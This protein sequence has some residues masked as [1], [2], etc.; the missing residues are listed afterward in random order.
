[1]WIEQNS[2]QFYQAILKKKIFPE[3]PNIIASYLKFCVD[4]EFKDCKTLSQT[5][6]KL[7]I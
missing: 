5:K 1:M 6:T 4:T 3:I 2:I 7:F